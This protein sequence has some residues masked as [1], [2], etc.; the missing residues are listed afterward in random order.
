VK[1]RSN[2]AAV[3]RS[4]RQVQPEQRIEALLNVPAGNCPTSGPN[5]R[6][7]LVRR[8]IVSLEL[9]G[10]ARRLPSGLA[11][12]RSRAL[13]QEVVMLC[14]TREID[15]FDIVA[16]DG[17]IGRVREVYFDDQRWTIRHLVVD[18]GGWLSGR[19]VLVSPHSV[20]RIDPAGRSVEV[21]LTRK[22]IEDAPGIDTDLPV[23]RQQDYY[24]YFGYPYYWVG[25]GLWGAASYPLAYDASAPA[26]VPSELTQRKQAERSAADP[27]L[28][29]SAEV[30]GYKVQASDGSIG[31]VEDFLF[32]QDSW[33]IEHVV[34]DTR[35][36]LPGRKVLVEPS[37]IDSVDW[38]ERLVRFNLS[39][40]A[41]KSRPD[42]DRQKTLEES[43]PTV[44]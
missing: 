2:P 11:K 12:L 5:A 6:A 44:G 10:H 32:D 38:S 7:I 21:S 39:C 9:T 40:E 4:R 24:D 36:W 27:H 29:S 30:T 25:G 3:I 20:K 8:E 42:Y 14:S 34:V 33:A 17:G 35:N 37:A 1:R 26:A 23:S 43:A 16:L 31:H 19:E 18:T 28:R 41:I 22:Q 15:G 13:Q